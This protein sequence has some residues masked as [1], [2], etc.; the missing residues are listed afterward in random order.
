MTT[1]YKIFSLCAIIIGLTII[2]VSCN[3]SETGPNG[4]DYV[5]KAKEEFKDNHNII[6]PIYDALD[7]GKITVG[8]CEDIWSLV[9]NERQRLK[10]EAAK[11]E[12]F[13]D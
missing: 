9:Y 8:E 4:Y 7:D 2:V 12:L 5:A 1:K 10:L 3:M 13:N 11:E 6:K